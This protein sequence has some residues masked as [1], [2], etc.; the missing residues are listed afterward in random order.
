MCLSSPVMT[1]VPAGFHEARSGEVIWNV[2]RGSSVST[3]GVS[4]HKQG[5]IPAHRTEYA[6][7]PFL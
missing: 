1:A 6:S 3:M 7:F 5:Q 2:G 4:D